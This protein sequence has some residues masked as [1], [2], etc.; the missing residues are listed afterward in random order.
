M[1]DWRCGLLLSS[2]VRSERPAG[3]LLLFGAHDR[4]RS[5]ISAYDA[6]SELEPSSFSHW[7]QHPL[8]DLFLPFEPFA[9]LDPSVS[10][11]FDA[12]FTAAV[13]S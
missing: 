12:C 7:Q 11:S 3:E 9:R 2:V 10:T 5:T 13:G 4:L 8:P 6:S 1:F